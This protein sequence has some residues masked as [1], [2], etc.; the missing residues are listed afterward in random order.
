MAG[1][2]Y[3]RDVAQLRQLAKELAG[4]ANGLS[5]L[6]QQLSRA[7]STGAWKGHDGERLRS[8]W[9]WSLLLLLKS[10]AAGLE[11]ACKPV[12]AT[13]TSRKRPATGPVPEVA[14]PG[15]AAAVRGKMPPWTLPPTPA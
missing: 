3:G 2:F 15:A 14:E 4:G 7:I 10:T 5:L 1:N 12:L 11:S 9:T 6:G 13:P 8:D